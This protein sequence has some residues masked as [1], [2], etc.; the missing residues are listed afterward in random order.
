MERV[1]RQ[2]TIPSDILALAKQRHPQSPWPTRHQ[3]KCML[4]HECNYTG[5]SSEARVFLRSGFTCFSCS[6]ATNLQEPCPIIEL[7]PVQ[8]YSHSSFVLTVLSNTKLRIVTT[9]PSPYLTFWL[10]YS[11]FWFVFCYL[12]CDFARLEEMRKGHAELCAFELVFCPSPSS[13][14]GS[15][16][17]QL[18]LD[19]NGGGTEQSLHYRR[20]T[21][22]LQAVDLGSCS[23]SRSLLAASELGQARRPIRP[24][25]SIQPNTG[26]G[27]SV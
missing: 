9:R 13:S 11:L 19:H 15:P 1:V 25:G 5:P 8:K 4:P 21:R 18:T 14:R 24:N 17:L 10:L 16:P 26:A 2:S 12:F 7:K 3:F 6:F 27:R 22:G 23:A 20:C